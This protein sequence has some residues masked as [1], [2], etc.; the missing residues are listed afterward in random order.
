MGLLKS[1]EPQKVRFRSIFFLLQDPY[2]LDKEIGRL[3]AFQ[4]FETLSVQME[5]ARRE[6]G[7][8]LETCKVVQEVNLIEIMVVWTRHNLPLDHEHTSNINSSGCTMS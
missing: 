6:V 4:D 3:S 8:A 2:L 5:I 1:F 7:M